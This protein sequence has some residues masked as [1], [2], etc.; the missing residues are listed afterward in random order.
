MCMMQRLL[1]CWEGCAWSLAERVPAQFQ[2]GRRHDF[3]QLLHSR[4]SISSPSLARRCAASGRSNTP[5]RH[6]AKP[7]PDSRAYV[8]R[9][10][11][12][13]PDVRF[14]M[15]VNVQR[16]DSTDPTFHQMRSTQQWVA[17]ID[18][19]GPDISV[20][21]G[22]SALEAL[23]QVQ[24]GKLSDDAAFRV[25]QLY[26]SCAARTPAKNVRLVSRLLRLIGKVGHTHP[27]LRT[28][29]RPGLKS[30]PTV[31]LVRRVAALDLKERVPAVALIGLL[32]G[33]SKL[34]TVK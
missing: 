13:R 33:L 7:R 34:H 18:A 10:Q 32:V 29:L 31:A 19:A 30:E 11:Q 21:A 25:E 28:L 17:T 1:R 24:S 8:L 23:F 3:W 5:K 26:R 2:P 15:G 6:P 20:T 9:L 22:V 12:Q 14:P 4:V 27:Q 16:K